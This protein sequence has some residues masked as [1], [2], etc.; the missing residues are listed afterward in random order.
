MQI[1]RF[2]GDD[3]PQFGLIG[4]DKGVPTIGIL[5]GDPLYAG[6]ELAG[7]KIPA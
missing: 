2:A 1:A 7:R 5:K 4:D 6:F 3:D